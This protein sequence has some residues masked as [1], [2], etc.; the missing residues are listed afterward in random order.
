MTGLCNVNEP[1]SLQPFEPAHVRLLSEWLS[2][3][4]VIRWHPDPDAR[5]ER[6]LNPPPGGT[7]AFIVLGEHPIGHLRWQKVDR[8]TLDAL[9]L[10]EIPEGSVDVDILIGEADCVGR[11]YGPAALA[12]LVQT[13]RRDA[14]VRLVGLSPSIDNVFARCAYEKAGFRKICEYEA[15][16]FR[17]CALM[18]MPLA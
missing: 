13:L 2:R 17:R 9:G 18:I 11:G 10:S 3:S 8:E 6:A 14:T 5:V 15:P 4:H 12:L 1:L 7:Q 16:G